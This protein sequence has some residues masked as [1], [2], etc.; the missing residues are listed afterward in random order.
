MQVLQMVILSVQ[1][2][3]WNTVMRVFTSNHE[4]LKG[5]LLQT[6]W[7]LMNLFWMDNKD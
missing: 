1:Q 4:L 5:R 6:R 2:C 3:F 7:Y